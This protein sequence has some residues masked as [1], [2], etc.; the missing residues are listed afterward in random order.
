MKIIVRKVFKL[1][2]WLVELTIKLDFIAVGLNK[3]KGNVIR[4]LQIVHYVLF[5]H[6]LGFCGYL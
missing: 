4:T 6:T 1:N 3:K 5:Q 2:N